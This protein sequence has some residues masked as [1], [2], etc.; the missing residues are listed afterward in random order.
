MD[1]GSASARAFSSPAPPPPRP[2]PQ[3]RRRR[4]ALFKADHTLAARLAKVHS[5]PPSQAA[6]FS[7]GAPLSLF[8][9]ERAPPH[10]REPAPGWRPGGPELAPGL[11]PAAQATYPWALAC[12]GSPFPQLPLKQFGQISGSQLGPPIKISWGPL[13]YSRAQT[14]PQT[15]DAGLFRGGHPGFLGDPSQCAV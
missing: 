4:V 10:A 7:A 13:K 8:L 9:A 12:L 6:S 1:G 2:R 15:N 14:G 11:C 3:A 5:L